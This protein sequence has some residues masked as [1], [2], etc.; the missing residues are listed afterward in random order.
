[1]TNGNRAG[2]PAVFTAAQNAALRKSLRDV[3]MRGSLSQADLGRII[4]TT[5]QVASRLLNNE[6]AGFSYAT[7]TR[8]VKHLRFAG[9]DSFFRSRVEPDETAP[10]RE[11]G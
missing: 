3:Q 1:M 10:Q 5:Q 11:A 9:V 4:G 8:L 2:H 6:S 7:A